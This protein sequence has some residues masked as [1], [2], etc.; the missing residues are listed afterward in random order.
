PAA[1][2]R[3]PSR[4]SLGEG[5]IVPGWSALP[6]SS[7][8]PDNWPQRPPDGEDRQHS[9]AEHEP[10]ARVPK[11]GLRCPRSVQSPPAALPARPI[12]WRLQR[13]NPELRQCGNRPTPHSGRAEPKSRCTGQLSVS[14]VGATSCGPR[15]RR[16]SQGVQEKQPQVP[17]PQAGAPGVEFT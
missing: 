3:G 13:R 1:R 17:E 5:T 14:I 15:K 16:E 9:A 2:R 6:P 7:P 4:S 10:E 12:G 11:P 8:S